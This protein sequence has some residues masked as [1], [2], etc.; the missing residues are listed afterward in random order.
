MSNVKQETRIEI[1]SM[2]KIEVPNDKYWGAQT[3]RSLLH[4]KPNNE[5]FH[6]SLIDGLLIVK[7]CAAKSNYKLKALSK[8]VADSIIKAGNE[9]LDGKLEGNFPL[10]IW[11]TGSGTQSNM[12]VNEVLSNR[13]IEILGGVMGSKSPV[14]PN[15]HVNLGQ[16]SNDSFPTAMNIAT[17]MSTNNK[18][19]PTLDKLINSLEEKQNEYMDIIKIGRT[20]MQDATPLKLGQEFSAYVRQMKQAKERIVSSLEEVYYLAQ[21]GTA[22]GTGLNCPVGFVDNFI[23]EVKEITK[24][25]FKTSPNKFYSLATHDDLVNFS[26]SLNSLAVALTK[27][28]N[29]IRFMGCGPR[30]G[31]SELILPE[32]EPGSSIMPGKVNPT[33]IEALTMVCIKV[34]SSHYAVSMAGMQGNLELNVYKP[35]II[36]SILNSIEILHT[37]IEGFNDYCLKGLTADKHVIDDLMHRSLMLVTALTKHI[38]YDKSAEIAKLAHKEKLTLKESALKLGYCSSDD[39]DKWINYKNMV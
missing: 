30:A 16:S 9:A 11:Q 21:G 28:A 15:D 17:V 10:S 35:L 12:N 4:F 27:I 23:E 38:G 34:M 36:H 7:I 31:I 32:N 26:G 24:L 37:A 2:G 6:K 1:D 25:P 22:V 14:H 3:Q 13:A 5:I 33:Q 39:F 18:L 8:E 19:I 29:D 20:H